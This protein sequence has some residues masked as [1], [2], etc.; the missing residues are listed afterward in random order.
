MLRFPEFFQKCFILYFIFVHVT[1]V[2]Q[3]FYSIFYFFY[4]YST[5][6]RCVVEEDCVM[7]LPCSL[8]NLSTFVSVSHSSFIVAELQIAERTLISVTQDN[9]S[10]FE[11]AYLT[12]DP[13]PR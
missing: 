10:Y 3:N 4:Y 11:Y 8:S 9:Y 7:K 12:F 1:M 2:F 13:M 5:S 6:S